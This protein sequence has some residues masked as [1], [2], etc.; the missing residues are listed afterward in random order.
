MIRERGKSLRGALPVA[1]GG[2]SGGSGNPVPVQHDDGGLRPREQLLCRVPLGLRPGRLLPL[3]N[4]GLGNLGG[5]ARLLDLAGE[6]LAEDEE[7]KDEQEAELDRGDA[8]GDERGRAPGLRGG[9][10]LGVLHG[11][12]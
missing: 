7:P 5:I 9:E 4:G 6:V 12:P 10:V 11:P 3:R 1:V 2:G 8:G